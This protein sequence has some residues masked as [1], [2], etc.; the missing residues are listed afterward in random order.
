MGETRI[1]GEQMVYETS[2]LS[3]FLVEAIAKEVAGIL[4]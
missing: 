1:L 3:P 2:S 4:T